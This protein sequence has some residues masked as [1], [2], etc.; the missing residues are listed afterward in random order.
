MK[1]A[2]ITGHTCQLGKDF[3]QALEK[4]GYHVSGYSRSTGYDLRDYSCVTKML[5]QIKDFDCFVNI[6]HPDYVQAQILYRLVREHPKNSS[7]IVNIGSSVVRLN[8]GWTD[9]HLLEYQTQKT[10][11]YSA[12]ELLQP[13]SSCKLIWLEPEMLNVDQWVEENIQ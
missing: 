10:A 11:L 4:R 9:T 13:I 8:P 5:E 12:C 2:A 1:T 6:A 3:S 7:T